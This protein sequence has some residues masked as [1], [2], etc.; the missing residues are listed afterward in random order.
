MPR[1][2]ANT[3]G[4]LMSANSLPKKGDR[5]VG[6]RR[7]VRP[8]RF[9]IGD[10]HVLVRELIAQLLAT[11]SVAMELVGAVDSAQDAL[12]ACE[13]LRPDLVLL[14]LRLLMPSSQAMIA[15]LRKRTPQVRI[16]LYSGDGS[17]RDIV[18]AMQEGVDGFVGKN[19][20]SRDFRE[21]IC[22]IAQGANYFCS[23]SSRLLAEI[24][25]GKHAKEETATSLSPRERQILRLIADG[26]TSKEI[27]A[28]LGLSVATIDTH[29]R[30]AMAKIGA[31]NAA[32][33]IRYGHVHGL[34]AQAD[35]P[36]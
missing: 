7:S 29:R 32:D 4:A 23:Q 2:Q 6:A 5:P 24:A 20:T 28:V 22:R 11:D 16:L 35:R 27:A 1:N 14:D 36:V 12:A 33:L 34:L 31:R 25:A 19:D 17:D 15:Q 26:Q 3:D 30:N 13:S 8:I 21:A 18:K 9:V 10:D